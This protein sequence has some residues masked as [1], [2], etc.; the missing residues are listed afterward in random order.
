M[1][2]QFGYWDAVAG[3]GLF[4][5]FTALAWLFLNSGRPKKAKQFLCGEE[6]PY[7]TPSKGFY[8]GF[9]EPF[10]SVFKSLVAYQSASINDYIAYALMFASIVA[11]LLAG[12]ALWGLV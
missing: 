8:S 12:S 7:S 5:L 9:E 6:M 1:M 4:A 11:L 10:G 3:S 2:G